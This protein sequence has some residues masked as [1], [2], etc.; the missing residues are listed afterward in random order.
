MGIMYFVVPKFK[1]IFF[2]FGVDLPTPTVIL[3]NTGDWIANLLRSRQVTC[4]TGSSPSCLNL[5]DAARL[6]MRTRAPVIAADTAGRS[7][8]RDTHTR[9]DSAR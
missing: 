7:R 8:H 2:D 1:T 6:A 9:G 4:M 5:I 3:I